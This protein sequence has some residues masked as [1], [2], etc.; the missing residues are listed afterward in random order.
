MTEDDSRFG[1][2]EAVPSK[3]KG[4]KRAVTRLGQGNY[5]DLD[6]FTFVQGV[7]LK[8]AHEVPFRRAQD[9][10][11]LGIRAVHLFGIRVISRSG[12][13]MGYAEDVALI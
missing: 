5:I 3:K 13:R 1:E 7:E 2:L 8:I 10:F 9:G 11:S 12:S 6:R 4:S